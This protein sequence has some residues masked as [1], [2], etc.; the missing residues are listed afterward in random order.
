LEGQLG[1]VWSA[2]LPTSMM[3][4]EAG[5]TGVTA[6]AATSSTTRRA[7]GEDRMRALNTTRRAGLR[8]RWP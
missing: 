5:A 4:A 1:G 6:A 7:F 8:G 3:R 2:V